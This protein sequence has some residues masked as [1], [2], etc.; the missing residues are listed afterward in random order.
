MSYE[1]DLAKLVEQDY[2]DEQ[3][4]KIWRQQQA[5]A[6]ALCEAQQRLKDAE[7]ELIQQQRM[8]E[9]EFKKQKLIEMRKLQEKQKVNE[10][11]ITAIREESMKLNKQMRIQNK[12]KFVSKKIKET[13]AE[14][15]TDDTNEITNKMNQTGK[16]TSTSF[17]ETST[18][19][20]K[21]G[22]MYHTTPL[23][24]SSTSTTM[25]TTNMMSNTI[26]NNQE[27][28]IS[29][30]FLDEI[31]ALTSETELRHLEK[32][33]M[34]EKRKLRLE[35]RSKSS[36]VSIS[37]TGENSA[38]AGAN[39]TIRQDPSIDE[40]RLQIDRLDA[41]ET[42][43]EKRIQSLIKNED[44]SVSATNG[45]SVSDKDVLLFPPSTDKQDNLL[46]GSSMNISSNPTVLSSDSPANPTPVPT[47][48]STA[49]LKA[50]KSE[51]VFKDA[52]R[53]L[54]EYHT[55]IQTKDFDD[56]SHVKRKKDLLEM[57]LIEVQRKLAAG[58][59]PVGYIEKIKSALNNLKQFGIK[60]EEKVSSHN[61][62]KDTVGYVTNG[63]PA[64]VTSS[65]K[66]PA[67]TALSVP[68]HNGHSGGSPLPLIIPNVNTEISGVAAVQRPRPPP[69]PMKASKSNVP[70]SV[71]P[72]NEIS[73][74]P[75]GIAD[76]TPPNEIK[77]HKP[78]ESAQL[79]TTTSIS[80]T[81]IRANAAEDDSN[82]K[83]MDAVPRA[84]ISS[85]TQQHVNQDVNSNIEAILTSPRRPSCVMLPPLPQ[86]YFL[87]SRLGSIN[88]ASATTVDAADQSRIASASAAPTTPAKKG[89][90]DITMKNSPR[91]PP[92]SNST[93]S[94]THD[95]NA[96]STGA[97]ASASAAIVEA[98]L[99]HR[100]VNSA[101]AEKGFGVNDSQP[102][103]SLASPAPA[104]HNQSASS[105][106]P[107]SAFD[108]QVPSSAASNSF[109]GASLTIRGATLTRSMLVSTEANN[110]QTEERDLSYVT[111]SSLAVEAEDRPLDT[112][113]ADAVQVMD[114]SE[115]GDL[116][117]VVVDANVKT[118]DGTE[119]IDI[120]LE[121]GTEDRLNDTEPEVP[122]EELP[123]WNECLHTTMASAAHHA[124]FYN[125]VAVLEALSRYFDVFVVDDK[126]RTPL[127]YAALRN[128]LECVATLV[129]IGG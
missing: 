122:L 109:Y 11:D 71:K 52:E 37:N 38:T 46:L 16:G 125:Y 28:L 56:D 50:D 26:T 107:P 115:L 8:A 88:G 69:S 120:L 72:I 51:D 104:P 94:E 29:Q 64:E 89:S 39:T 85:T 118:D 44:T 124:A 119:D 62:A 57:E 76:N 61:A 126:G 54:R 2:K 79:T 27:S 25:Q 5:E 67:H 90:I 13:N 49:P 78:I 43:I 114:A 14:G 60:V 103:K 9:L 59:D 117:N 99:D 128:N 12:A 81:E 40:I 116:D 34:E 129:S 31:N 84:S 18:T 110:K 83:G 6:L 123:G 4:R 112:E 55:L 32:N 80:V 30:K 92:L 45:T 19:F 108:F 47:L 33:F 1:D 74:V 70:A 95:K 86:E 113:D 41:Q 111:I 91:L 121:E 22:S 93:T 42:A 7:E 127:F 106:K 68:V 23:P 20:A 21:Q 63:M 98:S 101:A 73:V 82:R 48:A 96:G 17:K 100:N 36:L 15:T 105:L 65:L 102:L 77:Q 24:L 75:A 10:K 87:R 35:M 58:D 97:F 53:I 66:Q 3:E